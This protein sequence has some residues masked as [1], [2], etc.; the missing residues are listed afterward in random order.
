MSSAESSSKQ[1]DLFAVVPAAG[2]GSR[3]NSDT[4]KQYININD[5]PIL[6][7]TVNRLLQI[8][9]IR[10]IVVVLD[11]VS[12]KNGAHGLVD[13]PRVT[14]CVGGAVRAESVHNGLVHIKAHALPESSVLVHDAARPCVRVDEI[15]RLIIETTG[16]VNGGLLAMPVT[17]TI[18]RATHR[19]WLNAVQIISK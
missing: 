16:D 13:N 18:K 5:L 10:K 17:D 9:S 7:H 2:S 6:T 14:T 8:E 19:N 1:G 3:M 4:A 15:R 12:F 11:E